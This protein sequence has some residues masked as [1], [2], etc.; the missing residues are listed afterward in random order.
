MDRLLRPE[1]L[2]TDPNSSTAAKE[3]IYWFKTFENFVAIL[4]SEGLNK[5]SLLTNFITPRLYE[6]IVEQITYADAVAVLEAL[7]V[8]P[9]DLC[10][11]SSC[12]APAAVC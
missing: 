7:F 11:P 5:L 12:H 9:T 2:D 10:T 4:P 1:R 3:W 6:T 8:K